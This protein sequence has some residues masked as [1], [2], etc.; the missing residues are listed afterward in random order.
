MEYLQPYAPGS[1]DDRMAQACRESRRRWDTWNLQHD[2][3][4]DYDD[5]DPYDDDYGDDDN[6]DESESDDSY[7]SDYSI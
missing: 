1:L 2:L 5:L 4:V 3:D 6:T 7:D